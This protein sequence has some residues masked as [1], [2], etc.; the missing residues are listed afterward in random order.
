MKIKCPICGAEYEEGK[1]NFCTVCMYSVGT[2]VYLTRLLNYPSIDDLK[3][4]NNRIEEYRA[5]WRKRNHEN[6]RVVS[7]LVEMVEV[8]GG[9]FT[10][11]SDDGE[12]DERPT[13]PVTVRSFLMSRTAVTI[14]SFEEFINETNYRTDADKD[15]GSL[16][17]TGNRWEKKSGV[18]WKCDSKGNV[19][20]ELEMDQAMIDLFLKIG[21]GEFRGELEKDHPVIHVSWNDA[22]A[23]CNWLSEKE[24]LLK[25]YSGNG[26]SINCNFDS[27]GYRLPTEAEWEF[28]AKGGKA[29]KGFKY[30]GGND[31]DA[32]GWYSGNSGSSTQSSGT[33]QSN[34]IGIHD[35][36]GNVWEWCWDWYGDYNSLSQTNPSGPHSGSFRV[37]RGGGWFCVADNCRVANRDNNVPDYRNLD[38]GFRVVRTK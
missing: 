37:V 19:R 15:G 14:G 30:S 32:V 13:H 12:S 38:Q 10:M 24:G 28:A 7:G 23:F 35:M 9:T 29:S 6:K 36:S 27:N 26:E 4:Y 11:G 21:L 18:N 8:E 16:I 1:I 2:D 3:L 25:T 17:W 33:K 22:I 34:E 5:L 31:I 20:G